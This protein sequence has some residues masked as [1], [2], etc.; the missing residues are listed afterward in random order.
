LIADSVASGKRSRYVLVIHAEIIDLN[1][2]SALDG[3][4]GENLRLGAARPAF[5]GQ[6]LKILIGDQDQFGGCRFHMGQRPSAEE[7]SRSDWVPTDLPC[8]ELAVFESGLHMVGE[9][10]GAV[11]VSGTDG[12][13]PATTK[14]GSSGDGPLCRAPIAGA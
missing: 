7:V 8:Q 3:D 1:V 14:S 12:L 9:L 11:R 4:L 10:S 2:L 5:L 6:P 13:R